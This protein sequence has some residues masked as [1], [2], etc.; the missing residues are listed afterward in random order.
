MK[1]TDVIM[2]AINASM[3]LIVF[4]L[5][6]RATFDNVTYL[7]RRPA[8]LFRSILAMNVIMLAFAL[9]VCVVFD[10]PPPVKIALVALA[11]SPVPPVLPTKEFKAGGSADYTI[12]LLAG[13]ALI[14]IVLVPLALELL[15][16][17]AG[18]TMHMPPAKVASIVF[19][20]IVIPLF[21]G[22]VLR[23]LAP[24][25]AE[26]IARPVSSL[27]TIVLIVAAIPVL[28]VATP[29][30]K[31]LIGNGVLICLIA[32][33]L[34]GVAVGHLLGG[35]NPDNRTVLALAT[36]T[37]HPGIALAIASINFPD[38]KAVMVVVLYHLIIAAIV[39]LPYVGWRKRSHATAGPA[40]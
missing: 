29:A 18:I 37:R 4:S 6:L 2:L 1:A 33:T 9:I 27:A 13:A 14:S 19:V 35:P 11:L 26:R 31:P 38:E 21:A 16:R 30:L 20:S 10:P 25:F 22:I 8:L 40:S 5:G 28:F 24:A 15:G 36:G 32:F 7:F 23:R 17:K 39:A 34:I 12:G 3:F